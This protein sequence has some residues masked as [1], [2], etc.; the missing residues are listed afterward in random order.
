[1]PIAGKCISNVSLRSSIADNRHYHLGPLSRRHAWTSH[2]QHRTSVQV[3]NVSGEQL[4]HTPP[5]SPETINGANS[6]H[7]EGSGST[8]SRG[9]YWQD[10][11][12]TPEPEMFGQRARSASDAAV[13][14]R[15]G[16][17]KEQDKFIEFLLHMHQTHTSLEVGP[18]WLA[19]EQ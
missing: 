15:K 2:R 5:N 13:L 4:S 18:C 10:L 17:L 12:S 11:L 16:H 19:C 7:T 6:Q 9:Q 1:M 14:R 8:G 3:V